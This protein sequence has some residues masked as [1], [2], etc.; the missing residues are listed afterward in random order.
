MGFLQSTISCFSPL[1]SLHLS[2]AL[3][4]LYTYPHCHLILISVYLPVMEIN[5]FETNSSLET[6]SHLSSYNVHIFM[7]NYVDKSVPLILSA[8]PSFL[9]CICLTMLGI[10]VHIKDKDGYIYTH[11]HIWQNIETTY[12]S[13]G[14]YV[15]T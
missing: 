6:W 7:S 14:L 11:T 13:T 1:S 4:F 5:C 9:K 10:L 3:P 8:D 12:I 2:L 15:M